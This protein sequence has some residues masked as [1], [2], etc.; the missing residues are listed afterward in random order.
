M[1]HR[2]MYIGNLVSFY[3]YLPA[4]FPRDLEADLEGSVT[5]LKLM[6]SMHID[7]LGL[8]SHLYGC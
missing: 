2:I 7:R 5:F 4:P 1:A 8:A 6:L 3:T